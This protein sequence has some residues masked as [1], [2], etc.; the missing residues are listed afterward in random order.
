MK[1]FFLP[2]VPMIELYV[3]VKKKGEEESNSIE[4]YQ[5]QVNVLTSFLK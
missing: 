2:Q 3:Q 4:K 5:N 1:T